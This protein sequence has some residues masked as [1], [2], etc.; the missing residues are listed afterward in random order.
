MILQPTTRKTRA[1]E[2]SPDDFADAVH[3][4][5]TRPPRVD[6]NG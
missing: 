3:W 4:A 1:A 6:I 2:T 5:A